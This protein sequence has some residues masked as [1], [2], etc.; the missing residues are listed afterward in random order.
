MADKSH[1]W[2]RQDYLDLLKS[3]ADDANTKQLLEDQWR[4]LRVRDLTKDWDKMIE[5]RE[6]R[7]TLEKQKEAEWRNK[8]CQDVK[9]WRDFVD[10]EREAF[11]RKNLPAIQNFVTGYQRFPSKKDNRMVEK[12]LDESTCAN[13]C[14]PDPTHHPLADAL[15]PEETQYEVFKNMLHARISE[16]PG[17]GS[18]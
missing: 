12:L 6:G 14:N 9:L 18:K 8:E 15:P 10:L 17:I 5:E 16:V 4:H 3:Q 2:F 11:M 13:P 7:R 1:A